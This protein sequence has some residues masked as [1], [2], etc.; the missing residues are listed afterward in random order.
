MKI[1]IFRWS[2]TNRA[3]ARCFWGCSKMRNFKHAEFCESQ[4]QHDSQKTLDIS[5][6]LLV[7]FQQILSHTYIILKLLWDWHNSGYFIALGKNSQMST[8]SRKKELVQTRT[9]HFQLWIRFRQLRCR[10]LPG[11]VK[12]RALSPGFRRTPGALPDKM[13]VTIEDLAVLCKGT[14]IWTERYFSALSTPRRKSVKILPLSWT[15]SNRGGCGKSSPGMEQTMS[16]QNIHKGI[17]KKDHEMKIRKQSKAREDASFRN[18][19]TKES[20][21]VAAKVSRR[22]CALHEGDRKTIRLDQSLSRRWVLYPSFLKC[23]WVSWVS[24]PTSRASGAKRAVNKET[25]AT[26]CTYSTGNQPS[27]S[28]EPANC[29]NHQ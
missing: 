10:T 13:K 12:I 2:N 6:S 11:D 16:F 22:I 27:R 7:S 28:F 23:R 15:V 21:R 5:I 20:R 1:Y 4:A 18:A 25:Y 26:F 29:P 24:S 14:E 9:S 17:A 3:N 19:E 8:I